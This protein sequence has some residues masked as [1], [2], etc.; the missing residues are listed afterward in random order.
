MAIKPIFLLS[1]VMLICISTVF[2]VN[3]E[4]YYKVDSVS[5]FILPCYNNGGFCGAGTEC[6]I[7]IISPDG[8]LVDND[9]MIQS[10]V[11]FTYNFTSNTLGQHTANVVC[12]DSGEYGSSTILFEVNNIGTKR[13]NSAYIITFLL[14]FAIVSIILS[15]I[16]FSK[17][18]F[19]WA[20]LTLPVITGVFGF[21]FF[22]LYM[23]S[24]VLSKMW[25][26]LFIISIV[27]FVI[28]ILLAVYELIHLLLTGLNKRKRSIF[29][30]KL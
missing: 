28:M 19:V 21:L 23:Y 1:F 15:I 7:T 26:T 17:Q 14:F 13:E 11:M 8:I 25:F 5:Q 3:N 22:V 29:Q 30:D 27:L 18:A 16:F 20:V 4:A 10:G 24:I 6:N 2:A 9:A 12:N